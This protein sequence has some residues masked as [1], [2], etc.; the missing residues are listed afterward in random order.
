M[1][2][3]FAAVFLVACA[4]LCGSLLTGSVLHR[5]ALQE[6]GG[7]SERAAVIRKFELARRIDPGNP[8][9]LVMLARLKAPG[10]VGLYREATALSPNEGYVW[11]NLFAEK[12][13]AG[14]VDQI[15]GEALTKANRLAPFEP[16][17]LE[18][19]L[20]AGATSW[21]S[22][23]ADM[24]RE[25]RESAIRALESEASFRK[26]EILQIL[27]RSGLVRLACTSS[28]VSDREACRA[29]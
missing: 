29:L 11:A 1:S 16:L 8:Q 6:Y 9:S 26:P 4:G 21:L 23:D 24:K 12:A 15:A 20:K 3:W 22:L 25:I 27:R 14:Q 28:R 18:T 5:T 17:V 10:A 19:V 13:R 7:G 2:H